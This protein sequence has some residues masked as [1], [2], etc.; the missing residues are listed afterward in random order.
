LGFG[1]H[2]LSAGQ[3]ARQQA[4]THAI[5]PS[6][7]NLIGDLVDTFADSDHTRKCILGDFVVDELIEAQGELD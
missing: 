1:L 7:T 6:R 5:D 4:T 2:D 3:L